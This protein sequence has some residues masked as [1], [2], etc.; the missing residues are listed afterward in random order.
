MA[1]HTIKYVRVRVWIASNHLKLNEDKTQVIW[2]GTRQQLNKFLPQTSMLSLSSAT[3]LQ[4]PSTV[5]NLGVQI[6]NTGNGRAGRPR[7]SDVSIRIFQLRQIMSTRRSLTPDET[8]RL[9]CNQVLV[10]VSG[11]LIDKLQSLQT[12][13]LV[14][15]QELG[16]SIT[17]RQ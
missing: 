13:S 16:S 3:A 2:L 9:L 7:C 4:F 6:I 8:T 14:L 15:S 1:A 10:G 12:P 11:Q 5:N 17:Q